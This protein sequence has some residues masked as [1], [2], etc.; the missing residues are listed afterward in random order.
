MSLRE[1]WCSDKLA[2]LLDEELRISTLNEMKHHLQSISSNEVKSTVNSLDLPLVFDCLNDTNT[3]Q[4]D[5]ACEVLSLCLENLNIGESATRYGMSLER[6][7]AHPYP[8]V[9]LMI[10]KELERN[11][12]NDDI[13]ID[14]CKRTSLLESIIKCVGCEDLGVASKSSN[15]L[16]ILGCSDIGI[17]QLTS[18]DL[19]KVFNDVQNLNEINR[20]R[21]FEI[22]VNISKESKVSFQN[23][24]AAGLISPIVSDLNNNDILLRMNIIEILSQLGLSEHGFEYLESKNIFVQLSQMLKSDDLLE[25]QLSEP[26]ILKFFGNIGHWKPREIVEKYSF[27]LFRM[28]KNIEVSD[29]SIFGVSIDAL[30][31]IAVKPDGKYA[32]DSLGIVEKGI[33]TLSNKLGSLPTELT[34]RALKCIENLL[35]ANETNHHISLICRKWF[36]ALGTNPMTEIV[37]KYSKNPFSELR[38]AG[39]NIIKSI[40][41]QVWGQEIIKDTPGLIEFLLDRNVETHKD[42]KVVKYEIIKILSSSTLFEQEVL[43]RLNLYVREGPFYVQGIMEITFEGND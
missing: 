30:G 16:V 15:I 31:Y 22:F 25:V 13:L 27:V 37:L 38:L 5:L 11:V 34:I 4:I 23:L 39:L 21:V 10:L 36:F 28:F 32:L 41:N 6:S 7:L 26:G 18:I 8:A 35:I 33:L 42:C 24:N 12:K 1:E 19:I 9:K 43:K 2:K 29:F 14:L 20:L 40:S 3:Q 17:K